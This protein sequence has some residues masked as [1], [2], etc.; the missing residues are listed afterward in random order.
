MMYELMKDWI[1]DMSERRLVALCHLLILL[2]DSIR[3]N[4]TP[5][6]K[7]KICRSNDLVVI[8]GR[9]TKVLLFP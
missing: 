1:N 4:T 2:L 7:T 6:V 5:R 3:G 9:M 8:L